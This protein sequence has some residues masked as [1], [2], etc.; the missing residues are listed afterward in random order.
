MY[1]R[2]IYKT[3]KKIGNKIILLSKLKT[4]LSTYILLLSFMFNNFVIFTEL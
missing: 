4:I 2:I 1:R 3:F